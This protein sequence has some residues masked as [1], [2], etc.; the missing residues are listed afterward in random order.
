MSSAGSLELKLDYSGTK[1]LSIGEAVYSNLF[2][3]GGH[4]W[5]ITCFP[6]GHSKE[7]QGKYLSIHLQLMGESKNVRAIFEAFAMGRD[8]KPSSSHAERCVQVYPPDGYSSWGYPRFVSRS[9]L[10][11]LYVVNGFATII[12][13]SLPL[14]SG[15]TSATCWIIAAEEDTSD[16]SFH[17]GGEMFHA[18]RAVL[19]ARSPL[20]GPMKE[21]A[22][23]SIVLH[24]IA[25]ATFRAMLRFMYTDSLPGD[26]CD[27]DLVG[28]DSL[29]EKLL[30]DLLAAA[31]R[32]ALARL[33]L[34]CASKL[35]ENVSAGTIAGTLD[36]AETYNC[37]ELKK[38]CID[39]V[40]GEKNF[41]KTGLTDGFVP[42][43]HKFG[44]ILAELREKVG[45]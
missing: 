6:H 8:G 31:D 15:P 4:Q 3:A 45:V 28:D 19:A 33:K 40:A 17:V 7:D 39:F 13:P 37:P 36:F 27:D 42:L 21:A 35:W 2:S 25:P 14:T 16:V 30:R 11:K 43:A 38:K 24:E 26:Y 23:A 44:S 32:Y 9:D 22:M 18:H 20:F 41:K 29:R 5:R 10:D 34:L 1:N 12:W